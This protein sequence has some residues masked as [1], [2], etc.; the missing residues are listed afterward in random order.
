MMSRP[1][2]AEISTRSFTKSSFSGGQGSC[3]GIKRFDHWT[4]VGK[5]QLGEH[6]PTLVF[7]NSDWD[8]FCSSVAQGDPTSIGTVQAVLTSDGGFTLT[9]SGN[10]Q[11]PDIVYDR[12]EWEA[13]KL[14]VQAG[15]LRGAEPRGVLVG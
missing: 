1:T 4:V 15:E 14:G 3:V 6:S 11:A 7:T 8:R 2:S 10:E 12:T 13:F 5:T 9:E